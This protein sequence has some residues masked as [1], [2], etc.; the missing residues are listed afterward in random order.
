M[1]YMRKTGVRAALSTRAGHFRRLFLDEVVRRVLERVLGGPRVKTT[2]FY[3][4]GV[5]SDVSRK[6]G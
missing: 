3:T 6:M 1:Q 5:G 4:Q 2:A